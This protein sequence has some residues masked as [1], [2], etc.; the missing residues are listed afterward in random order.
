MKS[1]I[2]SLVLIISF[3]LSPAF[4]Q[5]TDIITT[6]TE[7]TPDSTLFNNCLDS[8]EKYVYL[9][10][11]KIKPYVSL[12]DELLRKSEI[13]S[14]RQHLDYVMLM[15]YNEF[16]YA[17]HLGI[18][19]MILDNSYLLSAPGITKSQRRQF[20]YL[21]GFT[22]MMLGDLEKAQV[23]FYD[24]LETA[25]IENDTSSL[26]QAL[27]SLGTTFTKA[28]DYVNA[29]NYYKEYLALIPSNRPSLRLSGYVDMVDAFIANRDF[30]NAEKYS[31]LGLSVADSLKA[32]DFKVE[33]LLDKIKINI[34]QKA[35]GVAA[36]TYAE[37]N[38]LALEM[39]NASYE[40]N[41]KALYGQLLHAQMKNNEALN[42]YNELIEAERKGSGGLVRLYSYYSMASDIAYSAQDYKKGLEYLRLGNSIKDSLAFDDQKQKSEY[43]KIKFDAG[44]KE[45]ENVLLN[46]RVSQKQL[47][48]KLLF[49]IILGSL[50]A[51]LLLAYFYFQKTKFNNRLKEEV[52]SR[53]F[54]L[55][56]SNKQLG[57]LNDELNEFNRILSHDLKEPLRSIVGFSALAQKE[58]D[59]QSNKKVNDYL[60]Y[61]VKS[62]RQ[63]HQL[64]DDVSSF[65][66]MEDEG[67]EEIHEVNCNDV[68]SEIE[69]SNYSLIIERNAKLKYENLPTIRSNKTILFLAFKNVIENGIK[70]NQLAEPIIEINYKLENEFHHFF[71]SDNGIGID[72]Q[73]TD[74]VFNM[75][76]RLNDRGA[77]EGSGLGLSLTKKLLHKIEAVISI[78]ESKVNEGTTFKISC[79]NNYGI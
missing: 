28:N 40:Q 60:E 42:I 3:G 64:I 2:V 35:Y 8:I 45:K 68:I 79:P 75:F 38:S 71:I 11:R 52:K 15:I 56:D 53:T 31:E 18:A 72:P 22:S 17:H 50:L 74:C 32:K 70:F 67:L 48:N 27:A 59:I 21:D 6:A 43:L 69:R 19:K 58:S 9:D 23:T 4:G 29:E 47:E 10:S 44:Q 46:A 7:E 24:M 76:E 65:Q 39:E 77:Y 57:I 36:R 34:E 37:A 16:N 49:V 66:S 13:I 51:S 41:C 61:I 54:E 26:L 5:G 55:Q 1:L 73:F 33:L 12:A 20:K 78:H 62:G 14:S 63:M 25:K 30:S